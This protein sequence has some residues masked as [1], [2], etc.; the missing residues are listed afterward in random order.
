[1]DGVIHNTVNGAYV[2]NGGELKLNNGSDLTLGENGSITDGTV[3]VGNSNFTIADGGQVTGG[4][5]NVN[6]GSNFQ[7]EQGGIMSGGNVSFGDNVSIGVDGTVEAGAVFDVTK[8]T[9]EITENGSITLNK[10]GVTGD[11]WTDGTIHLNGGELN[12]TGITNNRNGTFLGDKGD[13]TI[14]DKFYIEG[15]SYISSAVTT[16]ITSDGILNQSGGNVSLNQIQAGKAKLRYQEESLT[17][18]MYIKMVYSHNQ[19]AQQTLR[20]V[21]I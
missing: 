9:V 1:M 7:I 15:D 3:T 2:Q 20:A 16:T 13:L 8:N 21:L 18:I 5:I 11:Q 17:L 10:D 4:Q 14:G 6:D 19:T 12:F